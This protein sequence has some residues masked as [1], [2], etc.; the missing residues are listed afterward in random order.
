MLKHIVFLLILTFPT[1][2]ISSNAEL[3]LLLEVKIGN[4]TFLVPA[5]KKEFNSDA[6]FTTPNTSD[7][8]SV[9]D[10]GYDF[11]ISMHNNERYLDYSFCSFE[12][13]NI[14]S[15]VELTKTEI[16]EEQRTRLLS[17]YKETDL[18]TNLRV[19]DAWTLISEHQI[20]FV[21]YWSWLG[22]VFHLY[23]ISDSDNELI[24]TTC[25]WG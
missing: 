23:L 24:F 19:I 20:V 7:Y 13:T 11:I 25:G 4:E 10:I 5:M 21:E 6:R 9:S 2:A 14:H 15:S 18:P 8:K 3:S 16:N 17:F 12:L 1:A 22:T